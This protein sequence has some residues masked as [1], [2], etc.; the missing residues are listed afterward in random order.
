MSRAGS[1]DLVPPHQALPSLAVTV[2]TTAQWCSRGDLNTALNDTELSSGDADLVHHRCR[3]Y[4]R[5]RRIT[6]A[7]NDAPNLTVPAAQTL[8]EDGSLVFDTASGNLASSWMMRL[9][10]GLWL[11]LL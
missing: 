8:L 11:K 6:V 4:H 2:Q 7:V 10:Q 3:R 1:V 5:I 9:R